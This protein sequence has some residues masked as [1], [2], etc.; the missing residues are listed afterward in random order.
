[1]RKRG[2]S[3]VGSEPLE[4]LI[5]IE[6]D[7]M[8][9]DGAIGVAQSPLQQS[10]KLAQQR[11]YGLLVGLKAGNP[12][13]RY[14]YHQDEREACKPSPH[15]AVFDFGKVLLDRDPRYLYRKMD[16]LRVSQHVS[17]VA[18]PEVA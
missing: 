5:R 11:E 12:V 6:A 7:D 1:M 3:W 13:R 9:F 16:I 14:P 17:N 10:T 4:I 18:T 2:T 15:I 8:N